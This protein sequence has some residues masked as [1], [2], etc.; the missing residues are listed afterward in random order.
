MNNNNSLQRPP[1]QSTMPWPAVP[2]NLASLSVPSNLPHWN[3]NSKQFAQ[4]LQFFGPTAVTQQWRY[5]QQKEQI[6]LKN[7]VAKRDAI[8]KEM[9]AEKEDLKKCIK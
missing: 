7:D 3:P 2:P 9:A 8:I 4:S 1:A 6:G 5:M